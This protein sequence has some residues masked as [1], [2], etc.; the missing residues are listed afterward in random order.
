MFALSKEVIKSLWRTVV[1]ELT[2][3]LKFVDRLNN[4][5]VKITFIVRSKNLMFHQNIAIDYI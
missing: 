3:T 2:I 4:V 1:M 5:F